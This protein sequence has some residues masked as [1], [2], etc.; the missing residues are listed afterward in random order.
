MTSLVESTKWGLSEEDVADF[1]S[2]AFLQDIYPTYENER[3]G[4]PLD[5]STDMLY[6]NI[7]WL[8]ELGY[9]APPATPEAFMEMA[10]KASKQPFSRATAEGNIGYELSLEA[11]RFASWT[12]AFGGDVFDYD[13]P[14]GFH[15]IARPSGCSG[16]YSRAFHQ[17]LCAAYCSG[18]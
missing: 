5:R 12:F 10:C 11:A 4:F 16:F 9:D 15:M 2:G 7:D 13:L 6:Y 17:W 1:F 8:A 3:L 14:P 18:L